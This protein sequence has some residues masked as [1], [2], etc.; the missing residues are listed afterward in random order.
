MQRGRLGE[1]IG[2]V[3][4]ERLDGGRRHAEFLQHL[5]VGP[6][7]RLQHAEPLRRSRA[8]VRDQ[9]FRRQ[10]PA[11]VVG[12]GKRPI[13]EPAAEN[14]DGVDGRGLVRDDPQIGGAA[15]QGVRL[16]PH[17]ECQNG[18]AGDERQKHATRHAARRGSSAGSPVSE[19]V[20][21]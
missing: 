9:D 1:G 8:D 10:P 2:Q 4:A 3:I 7:V 12:R 5:A 15:Q 20:V 21:I 6:Y 16:K 17:P 19:R 18:N 14:R 11:I 13:L